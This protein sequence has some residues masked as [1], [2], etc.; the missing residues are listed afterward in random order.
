L[1]FLRKIPICIFAVLILWQFSVKIQKHVPCIPFSF[2]EMVLALRRPPEY[3]KAGY[4]QKVES[5]RFGGKEM[6]FG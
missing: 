4:S 6:Q 2:S 3:P 5:G 1:K